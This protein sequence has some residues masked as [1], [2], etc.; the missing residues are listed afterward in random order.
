MAVNP[1][2]GRRLRV[3]KAKLD[4]AP[5]YAQI[6]ESIRT[7]MGWKSLSG[8]AVGAWFATGQEPDSFAVIP[9]L[10]AALNA[11]PAA[12]AWGDE[13]H[14]TRDLPSVAN[15]AGPVHVE[16]GAGS[17]GAEEVDVSSPTRKLLQRGKTHR[18]KPS[19]K[20]EGGR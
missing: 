13:W 19:K 6:A 18:A 8:Q 2:F 7:Q 10:A 12:L 4:K 20:K 9:A 14:S 5:T 11:D 3:A 1:E 16:L 17:P 15:G